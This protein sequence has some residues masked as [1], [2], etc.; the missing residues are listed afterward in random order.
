[1]LAGKERVVSRPLLVV[2]VQ[3]GFV[4]DFTRHIPSRIATLI[5]RGGFKPILFTRFINSEGSS[6]RRFLDWHD[7]A[8]SPEI[9]L[10]DEV[11]RFADPALVF[12]KPGYAGI[13]DELAAYLKEQEI[14]EIAIAGIDTDM[15]VLKVAMDA[16]DHGIKPIV[17]ADCCASTSG[18]QSHFAGLAIL[19]R[20]IGANQL[21][22]AGLGAGPLGAP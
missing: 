3:K 6:Y 9:D 16:F 1:M 17:F 5:E 8:D 18:L 15:C 13:S 10:A 21:H 11:S 14:D 12:S 7:C 20:N 2:D 19:A 4:N 22:D